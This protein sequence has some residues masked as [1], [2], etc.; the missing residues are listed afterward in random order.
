[1]DPWKIYLGLLP[2]PLVAW[3]LWILAMKLPR[4]PHADTDRPLTVY[5]LAYLVGGDNRVV[6]TAIAALVERGVLRPSS[7]GSIRATGAKP[8]EPLE[9]AV[10]GAASGRTAWAIVQRVRLSASVRTLAA[11]LARRGLLAGNGMARV[12]YR[13]G[14]W[15]YL[16]LLGAGVAT[17]ALLLVQGRQLGI[18]PA[19]L[20]MNAVACL[21]TFRMSR[22]NAPVRTTPRGRRV[23]S[24]QRL[25]LHQGV[26]FAGAAG[27][28]AVGGLAM[29]PD[30]EL[31]QALVLPNTESIWRS[32]EWVGGGGGGGGGCGGGGGGGCGGGGG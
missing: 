29:Y 28:V 7:D 15:S 27:A 11:D 23:L 9:A 20:V 8:S 24:M 13:S 5:E 1:M 25:R 32:D 17:V 6:E 16:V 22:E 19:L 26:G 14:F 30:Q 18:A 4:R 10:V 31:G 3:A 12:I 2:L 21:L